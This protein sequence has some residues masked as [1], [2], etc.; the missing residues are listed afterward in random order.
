MP[1]TMTQSI[2]DEVE[3]MSFKELR[4]QHKDIE[5]HIRK[6][7]YGKFELYYRGALEKEIMRRG[8]E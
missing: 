5:T 1:K 4:R 2:R 3:E 6:F 8:G 7:S